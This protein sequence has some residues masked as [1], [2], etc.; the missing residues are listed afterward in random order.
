MSSAPDQAL[1]PVAALDAS[2]RSFVAFARWASAFVVMLSHLRGVMFVGWGSLPPAL[3]NALVW[4]FY[5][6]TAFYHEAVVVFF[7][8]SGFLIA[9]PNID[10]VRISSFSPGSYAVD[11]FTRIYVTAFPAMVL[12]LAADWIG[13]N[14]LPGAG[15]YDGTNLLMQDRVTGGVRHDS[16]LDLGRNLLMLQPVHAPMLGSN[17]P[18]WSLS[19]EVWFYVWFGLTAW[20][21]QARRRSAPLV[22]GL[23]TLGLLLFHWTAIFYVAIWCFGA[24]AYQWSRWPRSITLALVAVASCLALSLSG[25][26]GGGVPNVPLKWTDLPLGLAFAWLLA[27]MKRRSYRVWNSSENF[28]QLFSNFSYSLYVIHYPLILCFVSLFAMLLGRLAHAKQGLVPD[29]TGMAIYALAAASTLFSA[30]IFSRIFEA[31][32]GAARRW[33]KSRA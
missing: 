9:G 16:L 10:R 24:I 11:R 1:A 7:V 18:L 2:G 15:F 13:R 22:I 5:S 17:I 26:L 21:L 4:A 27:L 8:L 23:A 20:S 31:R 30:Y 3:H 32:T 19:Y 29:G 25:R 14:L 12:T 6:A 33:L 28:N